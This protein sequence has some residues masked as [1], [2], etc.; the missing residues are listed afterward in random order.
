[1]RDAA[2]VSR[3]GRLPEGVRVA[4]CNAVK[5]VVYPIHD[6]VERWYHTEESLRLAKVAGLVMWWHLFGEDA[7]EADL[8]D[9]DPRTANEVIDRCG[10]YA[11]RRKPV[12]LVGR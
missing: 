4:I 6:F 8:R 7:D 2:Q 10:E 1:M 3:F 9:G 12:T 11:D 5:P